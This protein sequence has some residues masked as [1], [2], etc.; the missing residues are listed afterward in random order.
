MEVEVGEEVGC[1]QAL[2]ERKRGRKGENTRTC[3]QKG[4]GGR[5]EEEGRGK[6]IEGKGQSK[7]MSNG[8]K[9]GYHIITCVLRGF[10]SPRAG[11]TAA[12]CLP[13]SASLKCL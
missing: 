4:G 1:P 13:F 6:E 5:G 3:V 9:C 2:R 7:G 12:A 8:E 10:S 11:A